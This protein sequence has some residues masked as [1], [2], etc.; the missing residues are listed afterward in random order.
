MNILR[1]LHTTANRPRKKE[2]DERG[3]GEGGG[4]AKRRVGEGEGLLLSCSFV[5]CLSR[6][7]TSLGKAISFPH[8]PNPIPPP[9]PPPRLLLLGAP[10]WG[11]QTPRASP[12][13]ST[14]Y[15]T[16]EE[17][18]EKLF[19]P[20]SL[21][22]SAHKTAASSMQMRFSGGAEGETPREKTD[23]IQLGFNRALCCTKQKESNCFSLPLT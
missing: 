1:A 6:G 9:P 19:L 4:R 21:L 8:V 10:F 23:R 16:W 11:P 13:H 14:L 2:E 17:Q 5:P 22:P 7:K 18:K 12:I 3:G 20:S 15:S